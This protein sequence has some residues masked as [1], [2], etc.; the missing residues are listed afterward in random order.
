MKNLLCVLSLIFLFG[1]GS[2]SDSGGYDP[3]PPPDPPPDPGPGPVPTPDPPDW[4]EMQS[5]FAKNCQRCHGNDPFAQSAEAMR[6][7]GMETRLRSTGSNSMP[8]NPDDISTGDRAR[9]IDFF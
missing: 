3:P 4:V 8:P 5:L 7:S 6:G 1:C 2:D 9:M